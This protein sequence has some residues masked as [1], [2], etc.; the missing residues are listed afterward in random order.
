MPSYQSEGKDDTPIEMVN[1]LEQEEGFS[2][3]SGVEFNGGS[4]MRDVEWKGEK[5][6]VYPLNYQT[7]GIVRWQIAANLAMFIMFGLN[8][9]TTGTLI[10]TLTERYGISKVVVSNIFLTQVL[11]YMLASVLNEKL[12]KKWG[13][14]GAMIISAGSS[15]IFFSILALQPSSFFVYT[16]CYLP[17]GFSIGIADS[18]AN[19]MIGNLETHKN[20]W[21]GVTHGLY[22]ASS[23]ITPP[24]VS[25]F[26]KYGRWSDFFY[27][28]LVVSL[29]GLLIILAAC[30]FETATKYDYICTAH[31]AEDDSTEEDEESDSSGILA[32]LKNPAVLLY[33]LYLFVYLGAE[34]TTGS[35]MFSYLLA[36]KSDDTIS[37]SYV[38]SA[39]WVGLTVGRFLLG[40][41]TKRVFPSEYRASHVYGL[42]CV[43]FY[44]IFTLVGFINTDSQWY[45]GILFFVL[46]FCGV[47]IGPLF[48]NAS[49]VALQV[50]P[51]KLHVSG[52]GLAVAIG[53]AGNAALPYLVGIAL[54]MTGMKWF[55]LMCWMLVAAFTVVW[56]MYPRYLAV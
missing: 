41:V 6:K 8:D 5:I 2:V 38:T 26:N 16:I 18:T 19:V 33:A 20:E 40:F 10:P 9:Q 43:F 11:G 45:I 55:P 56:L 32:L 12:H 44:T 30:R 35:W 42:C 7:V 31:K 49:I 4:L 39:F 37:M 36:T 48:P 25:Y 14:R 22:G 28:P 1:L 23:M 13:M 21:M 34:I 15:V 51:R 29:L 46:F 27:I 53:G 50:L 47:F 54:H 24:I 3:D 52:V 17:I